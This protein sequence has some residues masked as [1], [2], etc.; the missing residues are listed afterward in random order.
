ML[1]EDTEK[2]AD[3]ELPQVTDDLQEVEVDL[4]DETPEGEAAAAPAPKP[5][6]DVGQNRRQQP[7]GARS[8]INKLTREK[9]EA[10][11]TAEQ[12][13]LENERLKQENQRV[14]QSA[15]VSDQAALIHYEER[16]KADVEKATRFLA[17]ATAAGDPEKIAQAT[18][19][20]SKAGSEQRELEVWKANRPAPAANAPAPAPTAPAPRQQQAEAPQLDPALQAWISENPWFNPA[21]QNEFDQEMHQ[22]ATAYATMLERKYARTGRQAEI[23]TPAYFAEVNQ[24]MR[25]EFPDY[26][27]DEPAP[28]PQ[29]VPAKR[30]PPMQNRQAGVVPATAASAPSASAN[31]SGSKIILTAEQRRF[32]HNLAS[33]GALPKVNGRNPT[34]EE[35]EK[36]YGRQLLNA[37]KGA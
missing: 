10:L 13:R 31:G 33:N 28:Q 26:F 20:V 12:L 17:E 35:A 24:H 5:E 7:G 11:S 9:H 6:D 3:T 18:L 36:I 16:V 14:K 21:D 34:P 8:R 4:G 32:A 27:G 29:P 2:Q 30:T 37:Q 22:E 23:G 25:A 15:Q 1:I 19:A